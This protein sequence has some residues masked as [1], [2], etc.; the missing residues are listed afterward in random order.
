LARAVAADDGVAAVADGVA[1][2]G[3]EGEGEA[4][5]ERR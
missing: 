3:G 5:K 1:G 2:V 4:E